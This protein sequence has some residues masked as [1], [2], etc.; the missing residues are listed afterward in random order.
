MYSDSNGQNLSI[1]EDKIVSTH[2]NRDIFILRSSQE[3]GIAA[4]QFTGLNKLSDFT[5]K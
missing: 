3:P 2:T 1:P 4:V 5:D